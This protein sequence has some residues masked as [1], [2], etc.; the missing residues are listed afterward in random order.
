MVAIAN[1][2]FPARRLILEVP[3][4]Q[5]RNINTRPTRRFKPTL[6]KSRIIIQRHSPGFVKNG[7]AIS[8]LETFWKLNAKTAGKPAGTRKLMELTKS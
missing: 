8:W 1:N 5:R 7:R 3:C 4:F 6:E 2:A